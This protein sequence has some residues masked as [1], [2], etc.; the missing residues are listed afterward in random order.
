MEPE[1]V[2]IILSLSPYAKFIV[3]HICNKDL[4]PFATFIYSVLQHR[5]CSCRQ[6][7]IGRYLLEN[8]KLASFL[9]FTCMVEHSKVYGI[10][11][12]RKLLPVNKILEMGISE[13]GTMAHMNRHV[14]RM[15]F[16]SRRFYNLT[17]LLTNDRAKLARFARCCYLM[18]RIKSRMSYRGR[19]R[20]SCFDIHTIRQLWKRYFSYRNVALSKCFND[21]EN[22]IQMYIH[23]DHLHDDS[24]LTVTSKLDML[25]FL[26]KNKQCK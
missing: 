17:P 21:I 26:E 25:Q 10:E 14:K 7:R 22:D 8:E 2:A 5:T 6:S 15:P 20:P 4:A 19:K 24:K 1:V 3:P 12:T 16:E 11:K 9:M 23:N 18:R 13:Q